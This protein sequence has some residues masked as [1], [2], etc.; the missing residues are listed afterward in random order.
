M[1]PEII[2]IV[3]MYIMVAYISHDGFIG[4]IIPE[5]V[6]PFCRLESLFKRIKNF[7][8]PLRKI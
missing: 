6:C 5:S 4:S 8:K 1:M 3:V 2:L 7:L